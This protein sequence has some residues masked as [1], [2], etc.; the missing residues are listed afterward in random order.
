MCGI[1]GLLNFKLNAQSIEQIISAMTD[2]I[3]HR[4]P[5]A[6]GIYIDPQG[7]CALGHRRL[8]IIDLSNAANQPMRSKC[9]N[10]AL[11]FNGEI[12]NYEE[13]RDELREDYRWEFLT[14]SDTEVALY[15]FIQFGPA[16]VEKLNGMF[17]IAVFNEN[18]HELFLFRDRIG[19][20]PL[21]YLNHDKVFAFASELKALT[22]LVSELGK[23]K[24]SE[25][26]IQYYLRL[27]YIPAPLTIYEEVKKFPAGHYAKI[28][29]EGM[30]FFPYWKLEEQIK[31]KALSDEIE[32]KKALKKQIIN[33]V[34]LR[35][36]ADVPFGVFLSGGIDSSLVAAV[37]QNL[38]KEKIKTFSIGFKEAKYNESEYAT[39]VAQAIGS[40]HHEFTV[41]HKEAQNLIL[42]LNEMYDEPYADASAIP[43]FL[44]SKLA[45]KSVKMVL[46]GDGGD[47]QFLGYGMYQWAQRLNQPIVNTFRSPIHWILAKGKSSRTKRVAELFD[48]DQ[49]TDLKSHV[50]S[51]EQYFFTDHNLTDLWKGKTKQL[52]FYNP[53]FPRKLSVKEE[54]A[55]F[56]L[57]YY[58]PDDLL[59]KVDRASMKANV[60]ARVPLLD[61]NMVAFS[62]NLAENL[63]VNNNTSKY[64]LKEVLYDFLPASLFDR[65]KW[66]FGIPI[67]FWL[68]NELKPLLDEF[69]NE[70][71]LNQLN[72]LNT[73]Y[74]MEI[75]KRFLNGEDQ[76]YNKLWLLILLV[77]WLE[78]NKENFN[79]A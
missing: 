8:S 75:K 13:I 52:K 53:E 1:T 49:K 31:N 36:K 6:D 12:Y 45:A 46:T 16:F 40:E 10:Y 26:A 72:F 74:V 7:Y 3:A 30:Q 28:D 42:A 19:I 61:H 78:I 17:A 20:K 22:C 33:S 14:N 39:A 64:L 9:G 11:V 29:H 77:Q 32:A 58:L 5:D 38:S 43:T 35:L 79:Y 41:S 27:G 69:I 47:E 65:P 48:F 25:E 66:G 51:A 23:F 34:K 18:T 2:K 50:F 57:H 73:H 60:E 76:L 63:K 68:A 44:V 62:L 67:R 24:L 21:Y 56:D 4:G 55:F 59:T 15:A 71:K 37:A 54:Q 70:E